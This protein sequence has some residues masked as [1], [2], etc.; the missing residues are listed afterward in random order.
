MRQYVC[1]ACGAANRTPD[2]KDPLTAKCGRCKQSLFSARPAE[3][4][5]KALR[6]HRAATKG[7]AVLVDVWAPWCG[8]CRAMAPNFAAAAAKLQPD[9][10]LLKL[11]SEAEQ[12][13]AAE[14]GVSSIPALLLFKDGQV[15]DRTVG[16][17]STD[18]IVAWTRQALAQAAA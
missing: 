13:A 12:Q 7:A 2:G 11:N 17:M 9:V 4:D 15:I 10:R 6:A 16:L 3:V 5:A 1:P 14:L 18:Q 8:P